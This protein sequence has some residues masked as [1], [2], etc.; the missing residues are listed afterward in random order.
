MRQKR[1]TV[2]PVQWGV[3][4]AP[5][6]RMPSRGW[7]HINQFQL[8]TSACELESRKGRETSNDAPCS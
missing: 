7:R 5:M 3:E 6:Q 4:K 8:S 2:V 1:G